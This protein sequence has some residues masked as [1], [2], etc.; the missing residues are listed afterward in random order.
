M[1]TPGETDT[2]RNGGQEDQRRGGRRQDWRQGPQGQRVREDHRP[3]LRAGERDR[4]VREV[5][6]G[7]PAARGHPARHVRLHERVH[8]LRRRY[9]AQ[10]TQNIVFCTFALMKYER[11][12]FS[13][14]VIMF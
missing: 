2:A 3:G 13:L 7:E 4:P 8:L 1:R 5:P 6:D 12:L 14:I 10:V 9:T 11:L